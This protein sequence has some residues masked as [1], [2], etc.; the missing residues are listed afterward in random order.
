MKNNLLSY[1][2]SNDI[3]KI[4]N[5][6]RSSNYDVFKENEFFRKK[7]KSIK[8]WIVNKIFCDI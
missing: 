7:Y 3:I 1:N 5:K 6:S 8:R 2:I 4:I